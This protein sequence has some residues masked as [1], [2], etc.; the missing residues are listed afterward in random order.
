LPQEEYKLSLVD[1]FVDSL[2][3]SGSLKVQL[4]GENNVVD[5]N[6]PELS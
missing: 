5:M 2:V 4:F 3:M 1:G 6:F